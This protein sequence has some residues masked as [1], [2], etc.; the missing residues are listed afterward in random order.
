MNRFVPFIVL[1]IFLLSSCSPTRPIPTQTSI[2]YINN[3]TYRHTDCYA[4]FRGGTSL[5]VNW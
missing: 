1:C 3:A 5:L 4:N 2:P